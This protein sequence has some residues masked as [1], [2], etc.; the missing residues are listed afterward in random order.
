LQ[1][2]LVG[3]NE[4]MKGQQVTEQGA[5]FPPFAARPNPARTC[6]NDDR[7]YR[8]VLKIDRLKVNPATLYHA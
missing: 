8:V 2:L 4:G 7:K 3:E 6:P 1:F 5:Q